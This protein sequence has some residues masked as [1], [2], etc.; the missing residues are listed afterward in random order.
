M[1]LLKFISGGTLVVAFIFC[2]ISF[3][4][5]IPYSNSCGE[6]N[7]YRYR[8]G[9]YQIDR[10]ALKE[11]ELQKIDGLLS[12]AGIQ[13]IRC[14]N[15]IERQRDKMLAQALDSTNRRLEWRLLKDDLWINKNGDIGLKEMVPVGNEGIIFVDS[16][17]TRMGFNTEEPLNTII[18]TSSFQKLNSAFYKDKKHIYRYYAMAY[19][20]SFSTFEE[21]DHA[22]FVAL[23][24]CYA[25]DKRHIYENRHGILDHVDYKTFKVK[26]T[27]SGC[28]AKDKDGYLSWSDRITEEDLNDEYVKQAIS[29][30]DK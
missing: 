1:R 30:L 24:D 22:T 5:P 11:K 18:D 4:K 13:N 29:E 9:I 27:V 14:P 19:G 3:L 7:L 10:N 15:E 23:G 17:L 28:F 25:K 2:L 12:F 16:Y 26:S 6:N 20:G 8:L 21:A